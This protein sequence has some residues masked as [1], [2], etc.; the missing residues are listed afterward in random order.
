VPI[1]VVGVIASWPL[2]HTGRSMQCGC[3]GVIRVLLPSSCPSGEGTPCPSPS[4]SLLT[5]PP[6]PHLAGRELLQ[7]GGQ[8]GHGRLPRSG[9]L[10]RNTRLGGGGKGHGTN[11]RS[12]GSQQLSML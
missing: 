1:V 10:G 12:G 2:C 8:V 5:P 11:D 6:L 4:P 3:D 9:A 7:R